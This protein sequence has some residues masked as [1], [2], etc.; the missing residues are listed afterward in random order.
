MKPNKLT[1]KEGWST[2]YQGFKPVKIDS[3]KHKIWFEDLFVKYLKKDSSEKVALDIG[4]FPG[5]KLVYLNKTFGYSVEGI[6]YTGDF[7]KM[8]SH[9]NINS[10]S[11]FKLYNEDFLTWKSK[12]RY[13]LVCS[14]G[15]V[16]HFDNYEEIIDKH[17]NLLKRDGI[18]FITLPNFR[19]FQFILR[20]LLDKKNLEL[21][22]LE[23][24]NL[25][26]IK[27]CI[28]KNNLEILYLNYHKTFQF[29]LDE[30]KKRNFMKRYLVKIIMRISN[31]YTDKYFEKHAYFPN[32][33]FSSQIACIAKKN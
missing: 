22:N 6:D 5:D 15:F 23:M 17:V 3:F 30:H 13:D 24:M 8:K 32:K 28:V 31:H 27:D 16:E 19:Y 9:M 26:K 20:Y 18:L 21:H 10:V 14:F 4:C 11:K 33:Y 7:E 25:K 29:W 12:K 2:I 1:K